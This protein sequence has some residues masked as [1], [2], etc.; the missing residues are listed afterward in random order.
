MRTPWADTFSFE[1]LKRKLCALPAP[2][3]KLGAQPCPLREECG[4][5]EVIPWVRL[6]GHWLYNFGVDVDSR[7]KM[8]RSMG[9]SRRR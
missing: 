9:V 7:L 3:C 4:S 8:R 6:H 2:S 5:E 1:P